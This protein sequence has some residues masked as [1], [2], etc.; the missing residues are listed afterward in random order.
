[1]LNDYR[2]TVL[3]ALPQT[4]LFNF[5][6]IFPFSSFTLLRRRLLLLLLLPLQ[7]SAVCPCTAGSCCSRAADVHRNTQALL[8]NKEGDISAHGCVSAN[9]M[10]AATGTCAGAVQQ[11]GV[12]TRQRGSAAYKRRR[13]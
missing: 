1:M 2:T 11:K 12:V 13:K 7:L 4:I 6:F 3:R 9:E 8:L 10:P 5:L